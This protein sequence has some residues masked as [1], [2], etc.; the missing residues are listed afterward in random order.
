MARESVK[1]TYAYP[2]EC[3]YVL[4]TTTHGAYK[5]IDLLDN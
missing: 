1:K 2:Y 5:F 3:V 4:T